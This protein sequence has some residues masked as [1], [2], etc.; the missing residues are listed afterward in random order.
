MNVEEGGF[1]MNRRKRE[2][3]KLKE[4]KKERKEVK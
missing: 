3:K 2:R 4:R 1:S